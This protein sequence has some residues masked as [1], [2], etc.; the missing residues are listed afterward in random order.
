MNCFVFAISRWQD[1]VPVS[2]PL[3]KRR[4]HEVTEEFKSRG[5]VIVPAWDTVAVGNKI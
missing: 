3:G 5:R 4:C 2:P 1:R